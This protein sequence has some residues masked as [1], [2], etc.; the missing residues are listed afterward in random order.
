MKHIKVLGITGGVGA[1]K[2]TV[3]DYL[4]KT[5]QVR[6]IQLDQVAHLLMKPGMEC[7]RRI[8]TEF[9]EEILSPNQEIDR[10]ILGSKTF[11]NSIEMEKLNRIVHPAVKEYIIE[12]IRQEDAK[13]EKPFLVLEAALLLEDHYDE[14]CDEIWYIYVNYENRVKRLIHSRGYTEEKVQAIL[15]NQK[16]DIEFRSE[17]QFIIDN[18]NEIMENTYEQID[19]GL[20]EH[21]FL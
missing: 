18:N 11:G 14:I 2:S 17:C 12:Q 15:K 20:T 8:V 16:A 3:L 21:G 6:V 10:R 1:G 13:Q 5:Y 19:R 4:Q 7:Y 9:G